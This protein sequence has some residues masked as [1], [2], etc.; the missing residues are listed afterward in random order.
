[1]VY[2]GCSNNLT[3][4]Y[5]L[6]MCVDEVYKSAGQ[7]LMHNPLPK[8]FGIIGLSAVLLKIYQ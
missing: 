1:M 6:F 3:M 8:A 4:C 2:E 7:N 5:N